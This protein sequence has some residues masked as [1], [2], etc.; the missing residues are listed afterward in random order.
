MAI[1]WCYVLWNLIAGLLNS[2]DQCNPMELVRELAW[3]LACFQSIQIIEVFHGM[4]GVVPGS[5]SAALAM[6]WLG[7]MVA[8]LYGSLTLAEQTGLNALESWSFLAMAGS[9]AISD[10]LRFLLHLESWVRGASKGP[11]LIRY[12]RVYL[13]FVLFPLGALGEALQIYAARSV[14][15]AAGQ[16]PWDIPLLVYLCI[17]FPG[18]FLSLYIRM[19]RNHRRQLR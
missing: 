13:P 1:G 18:G 11:T 2:K 19:V 17:V 16:S 9:W 15:I 5:S 14:N 12:L 10:T 3:D 4:F 6:L 7:R 8:A